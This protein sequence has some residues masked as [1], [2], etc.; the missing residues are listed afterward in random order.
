MNSHLFLKHCP[1]HKVSTNRFS[2]NGKVD[3]YYN[4]SFVY[5]RELAP[6]TVSLTGDWVRGDDS[7]QCRYYKTVDSLLFTLFYCFFII[8]IS[9][10]SSG[11]CSFFFFSVFYVM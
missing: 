5:C 8:Y 3:D 11:T 1:V 2:L 4:T 10:F 6:G 9:R 7:K